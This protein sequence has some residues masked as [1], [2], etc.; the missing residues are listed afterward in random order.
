MLKNYLFLG[1]LTLLLI[2]GMTVNIS[3]LELS[4]MDLLGGVAY[5]TFNIDSSHIDLEDI[6]NAAPGLY[7]GGNYPLDYRTNLIIKYEGFRS[8]LTLNSFLALTS[9]S[10][11]NNLAITGGLGYYTGDI[12]EGTT[13]LNGN[14]G[15]L[16]GIDYER[17]FIENIN[18]KAGIDYRILEMDYGEEEI[19][20]LS[21][22]VLS[23]GVNYQF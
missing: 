13:D 2:I 1:F 8:D 18:L 12:V 4:E 9:Y 10:L 23:A 20:D 14:I 15:Y 16:L 3:A 22:P 19:L 5:T 7:I 21:G 11:E 6:N 17:E